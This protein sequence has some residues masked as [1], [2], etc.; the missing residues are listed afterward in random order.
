M[1]E[2]HK[3]PHWDQVRRNAYEILNV[4]SEITRQQSRSGAMVE[5]IGGALAHPMFFIG[6]LAA[7]LLW[8]VLN[9]PIF[10]W[11]DPWDPYPFVFLATVAS[12]EA[13]FIALLV[14]M[15][16]RRQAR[17]AELREEL[18]LQVS[19]H[20][21]RQITVSLRLLAEVEAGLEVVSRQDPDLLER[22]QNDLDPKQL[23]RSLRSHLQRD[24][25]AQQ[26]TAP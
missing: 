22:L 8:L 13:P 11:F 1:V 20:L 3:S 14:L 6:L 10:P 26:A 12:V 19:L 15:Y 25:D 17:I 21:E 24:E 2:Q 16:Q 18:H 7:H 5:A 9:L 4:R 23:M